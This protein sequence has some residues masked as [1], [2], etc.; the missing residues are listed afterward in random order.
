MEQDMEIACDEE[1][2]SKASNEKRREYSDVIM[3][4]VERSRYRG[5][6][7][8]M[9]YVKGGGFLKR[10]FA[11]ILNGG[12]KKN[13]L[14]LA[15][16]ICLF[17]LFIGCAIQLQSDGKVYANGEPEAEAQDNHTKVTKDIQIQN[18]EVGDNLNPYKDILD[19]YYQAIYE[20]QTNPEQF[21]VNNYGGLILS[22]VNPYW[23]LENE[24]NILSM[25]GFAYVD[26]NEDGI[27]ELALGWIDNEFWNMDEGYVFAVYTI[28][29]GKAALAI[30]GW[31]RCLYVIGKDGYLYNSGSSGA[32]ESTYT[33]Y[34]FS[35]EKED[36]LEPVEEFYSYY[37]YDGNETLWEHI[38]NPE[39]IN[40]IEY[41]EKHLDLLTDEDEAET[42]GESWMESGIEI[43]YT[44]F[45]DYEF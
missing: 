7:V 37:S 44:L 2:V 35:L 25:V 30:E 18:D 23:A 5:N 22:I 34:K 17:A 24:Q 27:D 28:V 45:E 43:D 9:G 33:K 10:R 13:G 14:L 32:D 41:T 15:G 26:L 3:S 36:F 39:D 19:K 6:A 11:C 12:K 20:H 40:V 21:D 16:S 8:S 4:W 31:E 1:V 29:D 38:T 42:M